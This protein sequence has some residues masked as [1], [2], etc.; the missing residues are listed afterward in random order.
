MTHKTGFRA[1]NRALFHTAPDQ[2]IGR[3]NIPAQL[4][5]Q[6]FRN[7]FCGNIALAPKDRHHFQLR[8]EKFNVHSVTSFL[9]L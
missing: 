1:F 9:R 4:L 5:G 8:I 3:I 7:M 6:Q 2:G